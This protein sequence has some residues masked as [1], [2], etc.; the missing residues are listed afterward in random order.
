M[1]RPARPVDGDGTS[2]F[3][4]DQHHRVGPQRAKPGLERSDHR[5]EALQ[6]GTE[7][8]ALGGVRV[9][10]ARLD[11]RDPRAIGRG[12]QLRRERAGR[13][14]IR[15]AARRQIAGQRARPHRLAPQRMELAVA[16]IEHRNTLHQVVGCL[17]Q[18]GRRVGRHFVASAQRQRHRRRHCDRLGL[19]RRQDAE[20]AVEPAVLLL[21]GTRPAAF[22]HVLPV[23]MRTVTIGRGDRVREQSLLPAVQPVKRGECGV[24]REHP[25]KLRGGREVGRQ[26]TARAEISVDDL[27]RTVFEV[28]EHVIR[29]HAA[30]RPVVVILEDLH[31][32]DELSRELLEHLV[33]QLN[34]TRVLFVVTQRPRDEPL[35]RPHAPVMPILLHRLS[36][37]D[38]LAVVR[39]AADAILPAE[40]EAGLVRR[41]A[42]S[43]FFAE[44]LVRG[45]LETGALTVQEGV[46]TLAR[47]LAEIPIPDTV[48]EVI[49]AR[50]DRLPA[51]VK[52]VSQVAAVI[53]RQFDARQ[54]AQV[55][56]GEDID[57][58]AALIE[59]ERRGLVHRK[60]ALASD[61]L[62]FG[63]SLT[64]EIAYESLLFKQ[65]RL[66]HERVATTLESGGAD[67]KQSALLAYHYARSDNRPKAIETTLQAAL[68]AERVPSYD[69][70]ARLFQQARTL[71]EEELIVNPSPAVEGALYSALGALCRYLAMFGLGETRAGEDLARRALELAIRLGDTNNV[72]ILVYFQ[73]VIV[74]MQGRDHFDRGLAQ[75]EDAFVQAQRG[76]HLP[77]TLSVARGLCFNYI[78]DGRL[79]LAKRTA[80]WLLQEV[81]RNATPGQESDFHVAVLW[82]KSVV[83]YAADDLDEA[84]RIAQAAYDIAVRRENRTVRGVSASTLAQV[85][86]LRGHFT[87]AQRWADEG[88]ASAERIGN[89]AALLASASVALVARQAQ[90]MAVD[91]ARYLDHLERGLAGTGVSQ[92]SF[93]FVAAAFVGLGADLDRAERVI[94]GMYQQAG[95]RLREAITALSLA[96]VLRARD[97]LASVEVARL[98]HEAAARAEAIGARSLAAE[99]ILGLVEVQRHTGDH[100]TVGR[101][102]AR[103]AAIVH[104]LGLGYLDRRLALVGGA[105][106]P[107]QPSA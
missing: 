50:L 13:C 55:L 39:G 60:G 23:E 11:H 74:M 20:Q 48:Q 68:A 45:L 101:N 81:Q 90:G 37:D 10:S 14:R 89:V 33:Q 21:I 12:H 104:D 106:A 91:S 17:R 64:Q 78:A 54:L 36:N 87:E 6:L 92:I 103:A 41:A 73:S 83:L 70:A 58:D 15:P 2:E 98:Y 5:I 26:V 61:T 16:L 53:G 102:A 40:L 94:R 95:G 57:L 46:A 3:G 47:P 34:G 35:W 67:A 105:A 25:V 9:P 56:D 86:L 32:I 97:G 19:G 22:E 62:R 76:A 107:A 18:A 1:I 31:W 59:L 71:A 100:D 75:A 63:E 28:V 88:L 99:A 52:R 29:N 49:A 8:L 84:Q 44:E 7:P 43:P 38:M 80:D 42:G 82:L 4:R 24:Q 72:P 85:H 79:E 69:V 66:L 30:L 51:P 96:A 65:R 27:K 93:R 77:T